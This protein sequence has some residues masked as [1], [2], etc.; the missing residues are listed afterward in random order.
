M[1]FYTDTEFLTLIRETPPL[2]K[3]EAGPAEQSAPAA[4]A[5][6][7]ENAAEEEKPDGERT[8]VLASAE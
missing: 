3:E 6:E 1:R 5:A 7:E 2:Q 8:P 4:A